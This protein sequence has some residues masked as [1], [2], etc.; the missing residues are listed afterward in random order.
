MPLAKMFERDCGRGIAGDNDRLDTASHQLIA[1]LFA[2]GS[3]LG[4]A[5]GAVWVTGAI[6]DI[7]RGFSW[8]SRLHLPKNGETSNP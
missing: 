3:H 2:E 1:Q 6:S 8:E 7:D 4:I 5:A